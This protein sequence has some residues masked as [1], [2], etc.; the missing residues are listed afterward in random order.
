MRAPTHK[1]RLYGAEIHPE[2][3]RHLLVGKAFYIA[4]DHYCVKGLRDVTQLL[5]YPGTHLFLSG[6]VKGRFVTIDEGVFKAQGLAVI[7]L[8]EL[9]FNGD[10]LAFVAPPPAAL[11]AGLAQGDAINP[12]AQTGISVEAADAGS[13][14]V[15]ATRL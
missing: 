6:A 10:F 12:G 8:A 11:V 1:T 4:Q 3:L 14:M 2:N 5:L 7:G 9:G 13:G 15:R